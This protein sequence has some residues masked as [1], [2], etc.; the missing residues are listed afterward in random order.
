MLARTTLVC[1]PLLLFSGAALASPDALVFSGGDVRI[2]GSGNGLVFPDGTTQYSATLSSTGGT[3]TA[4]G[5]GSGIAVTQVGTGYGISSVSTTGDAVHAS[6][7]GT[8]VYG[9]SH[10]SVGVLGFTYASGT[11]N[12]GVKGFSNGSATGVLGENNGGGYGVYGFSNTGTAGYFEVTSGSGA[13]VHGDASGAGSAGEFIV[14]NPGNTVNALYV[15][16]NGL[17]KAGTFRI[18]N[19]NNE[20]NALFASTTGR[21][22][23]GAFLISNS[24]NP[25]DGLNVQTNGSGT[26]LFSHTSGAGA[27]IIGDT[28]GTSMAGAFTIN[29]SSN[30]AS[31][32]YAS[33]NGKGFSGEFSGGAG[34]R[35][36]GNLQVVGAVSKLAGSFKIDHPLDPA[37]KFLSHSFVESPDMMNMYNGIITTDDRGYATVQLPDWFQALNRDFRY[38]LT[39][40]DDRDSADFVQAKIVGK[41]SGNSFTLRTSKPATEVSW[42]VTGIRQDAWANAHRIPVEELKTGKDVG[43]YLNP[44]LFVQP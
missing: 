4:N 44:G 15:Y 33:T 24:S 36:I 5:S 30:S 21:G 11:E 31:S 7:S 22:G 16:T 41:V 38:Q 3:I 29:N 26:A 10:N 14:N 43:T 28:T 25:S 40:I 42:Q 9:E 39:V 17:G 13:A 32:L 18:N 1:M 34:V 2:T 12:A 20:A 27:A 19:A 35:I 6:A 23:A 37:N 8:G